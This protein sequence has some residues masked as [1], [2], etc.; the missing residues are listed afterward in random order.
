MPGC[1]GCGSGEAFV[2]SARLV[3][4]FPAG[5]VGWMP[6][7]P[8]LPLCPFSEDLRRVC[9]RPVCTHVPWGEEG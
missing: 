2:T 8:G 6:W 3:N 1:Q 9:V 4:T 5:W 7:G